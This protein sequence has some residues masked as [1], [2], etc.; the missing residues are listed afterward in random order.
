MSPQFSTFEECHKNPVSRNATQT[1]QH[2]V[3]CHYAHLDQS[4]NNKPLCFTP[5]FRIDRNPCETLT[6]DHLCPVRRCLSAPLLAATL[7]MR[8]CHPSLLCAAPHSAMVKPPRISPPRGHSLASSL[9]SSCRLEPLAMAVLDFALGTER[10]VSEFLLW[11]ERSVRRSTG[12]GNGGSSTRERWRCSAVGLAT[13]AAVAQLCGK[14]GTAGGGR[15]QVAALG[16]R[17][18]GREEGHRRQLG[19]KKEEEEM[20]SSEKRWDRGWSNG[21]AQGHFWLWENTLTNM[22]SYSLEYWSQ[23]NI[24]ASD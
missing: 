24:M 18:G 8:C 7:P 5:Y 9:S 16:G 17:A 22:R 15:K 13:V 21:L 10:A 20:G 23:M 1:F 4:Q 12:C 14:K 11:A 6:S 3:R 2:A 19:R